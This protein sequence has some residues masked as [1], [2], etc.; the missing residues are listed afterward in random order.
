MIVLRQGVPLSGIV[1]DDQGNPAPDV[2]VITRREGSVGRLGPIQDPSMGRSAKDGTFRVEN[3]DPGPRRLTTFS[4]QYAAASADVNIQAGMKPVELVVSRGG[5]VN[6]VVLDAHGNP[7]AGAYVSA[8]SLTAEGRR[9]SSRRSVADAG[10]HFRIEG[11]VLS[12]S[13]N[14]SATSSAGSGT[15]KDVKIRPEPYQITLTPRRPGPT[16]TQITVLDDATGAPITH[17]RLF[18]GPQF[19]LGAAPNFSEGLR[20]TVVSKDGKYIRRGGY[21]RP[22]TGLAL[23]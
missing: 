18:D 10:G 5:S 4:N 6:G 2:L 9:S 7:V 8:S 23:P 11:L 3:M 20:Y 14:L 17:Y 15:L 1:R 12:G 16:G 21:T 22:I 19:D 13:L